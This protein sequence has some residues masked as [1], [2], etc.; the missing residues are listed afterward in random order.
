MIISSSHTKLYAHNNMLDLQLSVVETHIYLFLS[1]DNTF[2]TEYAVKLF[3]SK[4]WNH[5][6]LFVL[7]KNDKRMQDKIVHNKSTWKT[8]SNYEFYKLSILEN[9]L[10]HSSCLPL[11][12][13]PIFIFIKESMKKYWIIEESC[14]SKIYLL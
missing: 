4:L 1:L 12:V 7:Y 2:L 3:L 9:H 8:M 6:N 11:L 14:S 13:K 10:K 5:L